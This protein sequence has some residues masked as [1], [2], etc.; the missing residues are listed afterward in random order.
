MNEQTAGDWPGR[1]QCKHNTCFPL[2]SRGASRPYRAIPCSNTACTPILPRSVC[3]ARLFTALVHVCCLV[4]LHVLSV[5]IPLLC[6]YLF[7]YNYCCMYSNTAGHTVWGSLCAEVAFEASTHRG[8]G[9][10]THITLR[11]I[12]TPPGLI[13]GV[14][15]GSGRTSAPTF[16]ITRRLPTGNDRGE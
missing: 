8:M 10:Q 14:V 12:R 3:T 13:G 1:P 11:L 15:A 2:V 9:R 7:H 5:S 4:L 16:R 6:V